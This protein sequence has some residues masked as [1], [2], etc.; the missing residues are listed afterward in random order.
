[1]K[2]RLK[3]DDSAWKQKIGW[4]NRVILC[5]STKNR[6]HSFANFWTNFQLEKYRNCR[7]FDS[8]ACQAIANEKEIALKLRAFHLCQ[9]DTEERYW[10]EGCYVAMCSNISS[11]VAKIISRLR[12]KK[13]SARFFEQCDSRNR[14]KREKNFGETTQRVY[15]LR[16]I[17]F[18]SKLIKNL[19]LCWSKS[20]VIL[21]QLCSYRFEMKFSVWNYRAM[22]GNHFF[23]PVVT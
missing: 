21:D 17:Y 12:E 3:W 14:D 4:L 10:I 13:T 9:K 5:D 22:M 8:I 15:A 7:L 2:F 18:D 1:M 11:A 23:S 20:I 16:R 19:I 6:I